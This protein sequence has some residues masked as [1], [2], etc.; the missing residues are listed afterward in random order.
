MKETYVNITNIKRGY[1]D[2]LIYYYN[3]V[4]KT[5]EIA[6]SIITDKLIS[7]IEIRYGQLGGSLP[8]PKKDILAKKGKKWRTKMGN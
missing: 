3:N 2:Q 4:G 5:S 7:T 1:K 8:I 6:G